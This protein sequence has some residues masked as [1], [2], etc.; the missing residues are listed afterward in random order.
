MSVYFDCVK[1]RKRRDWFCCATS[2]RDHLRRPIF[3]ALGRTRWFSSHPSC[4]NFTASPQMA[5]KE[6]LVLLRKISS[7]PPVASHLRCAPSN[8][9]V[10]ISSFL[11]QFYGFALNGG[12]RGTR[13]RTRMT[14][15]LIVGVVHQDWSD[16]AM[17]VNPFKLGD[18]LIRRSRRAIRF[19]VLRRKHV[20]ET[21]LIWKAQMT[22]NPHI[23][24][25]DVAE[26]VGLSAIRVRQILR[27]AKLHPEIQEA[28]LKLSPK[29]ARKHY[30][31]RLLRE[32]LP[33]S[34]TKQLSQF[35]QH[36]G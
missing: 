25:S 22:A 8:P 16:G 35:R 11:P 18:A 30:P 34:Q 20:L 7:R 19:K 12:E 27:F 29:Q 4:R 1:W 32:W 33:L 14:Q 15:F 28:I 10:L 21:A 9:M 3:A 24:P 6:G 31:E 23:Q 17:V 13:I 26:A 5:E 36:M 2:V